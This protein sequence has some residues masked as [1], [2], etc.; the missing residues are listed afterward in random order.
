[1]IEGLQIER[2]VNVQI[3]V[4]AHGV[5]QRETVVTLRASYPRVTGIISGV[6]IDPLQIRQLVQRQLVAGCGL[7][8]V[9]ERRTQVLDAAPHGVFPS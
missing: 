7:L 9:V 1:M 8:L 2:A 6:G 4:A 3:A 5:T